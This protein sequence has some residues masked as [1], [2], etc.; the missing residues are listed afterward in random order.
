MVQPK[1]RPT[2]YPP[3][4]TALRSSVI[5]ILNLQRERKQRNV[6]KLIRGRLKMN[7]WHKLEGQHLVFFHFQLKMSAGRFLLHDTR[8]TVISRRLLESSAWKFSLCWHDVSLWS[9]WLLW[10]GFDVGQT[11]ILRYIIDSVRRQ[12][13]VS[14]K[15]IRL[16]FLVVSKDQHDLISACVNVTLL[17]YTF[18][19]VFNFGGKS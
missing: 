11:R 12:P 4:P 18:C 13:F 2:V 10:Q 6:N 9:F 17:V 19:V 5:S 7:H 8:F 16:Y 15:M 1:R 3:R 14:R